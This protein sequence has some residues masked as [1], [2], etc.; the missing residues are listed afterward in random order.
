MTIAELTT[1]AEQIRNEQNAGA[2]TNVRIGDM[3]LAIIDTLQDR[4]P[5][6]PRT[7]GSN[8]VY[9]LNSINSGI[10]VQAIDITEMMFTPFR[11]YESLTLR[12]F[13]F[14]LRAIAA[15]SN[16]KIAIYN[17]SLGSP[18][19]IV[20]SS[21]I[22]SSVGSP[23]SNQQFTFSPDLVLSPGAY[24]IALQTD[25]DSIEFS[26]CIHP[27]TNDFRWGDFSVTSQSANASSLFI[28]NP[29]FAFP[30]DV[31]SESFSPSTT[32]LFGSFL[33]P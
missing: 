13:F 2:N 9:P 21:T 14:R 15:A 29:T 28:V 12:F 8:I 4:S 5:L 23:N 6:F 27:T 24:W 18:S 3:L 10:E 25:D 32:F 7:D 16:V 19:T 22:T 31:S 33:T 17:D 26:S 30:S 11:V 20:P 1:L